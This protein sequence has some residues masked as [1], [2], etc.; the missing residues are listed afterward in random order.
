MANIFASIARKA[1]TLSPMMEGRERMGI[2]ELIANYPDGVTI[3]AFDMISTGA[4]SYPVLN[5]AEDSNVFVFGGAIMNNIV[6]D[7]LEHFEGDIDTANNALAAA[8][9]VRV[10]FAKSRTKSGN[11]LTTVQV[12]D[13]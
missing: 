13:D 6:H 12:L 7:W 4:D 10:K 2:D 9:G 11:N 3:T 8:G 1:T 5:I